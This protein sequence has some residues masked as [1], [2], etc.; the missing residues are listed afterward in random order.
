MNAVLSAH[1]MT[2]AGHAGLCPRAHSWLQV[3]DA[4]RCTG[5]LRR[6]FG[7]T[8]RIA[9]WLLAISVACASPAYAATGPNTPAPD[10][11]L[12]ARAGS[13]VSLSSLKGQVVLINVWATWCGPCRKE[14]PLLEQIF[15]RYK[16]LGFTL[17][18]VN[19]EEDSTLAESFL[20]DTPVSFPILFDRQ[21]TVSRLYEVTAMP[22]T[23][24][25]DRQGRV[26]F[27]HHGY[28]PGTE[29]QYQDQ[30]RSLLRE[31]S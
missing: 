31:T 7:R 21:N 18:G 1:T 13:A 12:P 16:G 17:L 28:Q 5:S 24:I 6:V 8:L 25:V 4:K 27:V 20:Q 30:I 3:C 26:R 22:S 11:T 14:M 15:Q 29:N 10:F 2:S 23:V 9:R 19:V